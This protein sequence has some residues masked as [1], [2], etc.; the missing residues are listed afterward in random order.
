MHCGAQ[1]AV[2]KVVA[3]ALLGVIGVAAWLRAGTLQIQLSANPDVQQTV[4]EGKCDD[5]VKEYLGPKE[6]GR[7]SA[8]RYLDM[9]RDLRS[10]DRAVATPRP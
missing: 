7:L 4:Y 1:I 10:C 3:F 8:D 2:K 6:A 9:L 5:I